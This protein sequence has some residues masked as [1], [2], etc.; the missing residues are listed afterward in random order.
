MK[1]LIALIFV[2]VLSISL[3]ATPVLGA[4]GN[5]NGAV[6]VDLWQ[7]HGPT[8][9]SVVGSVVMNTTASGE[10]IVVVNIDTVPDQGADNV[11]PPLTGYD[12]RVWINGVPTTVSDVLSTNAN[13]QG[14]ATVKVALG[15]YGAA[16]DITVNIVVRD[17]NGTGLAFYE[18][19]WNQTLVPLK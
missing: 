15:D 9:D 7:I 17:F 4:P 5:G 10:L 12:V 3:M 2:L 16:T 8:P 18:T 14:N 6:K 13:G 11:Q 1:K 19:L